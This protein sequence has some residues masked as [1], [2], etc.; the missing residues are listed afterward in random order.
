M[1]FRPER[2]VLPELLD[3]ASPADAACNLADLRRINRYLGGHALLLSQTARLFRPDEVFTA[4]DVGAASGDNARALQARFRQ[5]RICSLDHQPRNLLLAPDPK[6]AADAFALP[7]A[8]S[9]FDLVTASLFLHHFNETNIVKL[10]REMKRV[11]A[12]H[13]LVMDLERHRLAYHFLPSTAWMFGWHRVTLHDGPV[14]VQA[15]FRA[16]ELVSLAR[17]AGLAGAHVRRHLPWFRLS[18]SAPASA[19]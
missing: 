14:S 18:L 17:E 16:A 9:A 8:E 11:A 10:L 12:R 4:L 3:E 2:L 7:F 1:G 6:I 15:G 5:A 13:I 19:L